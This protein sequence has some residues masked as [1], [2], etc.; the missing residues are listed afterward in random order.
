MFQISIIRTEGVSEK[1]EFNFFL[2]GKILKSSSTNSE[3]IYCVPKKANVRI[4]LK[5]KI[6]KIPILSSSFRTDILPIEEFQWLPLS[7]SP[8]DLFT[9]LPD[10]VNVPRVLIHVSNGFLSPVGEI[11]EADSEEN[12]GIINHNANNC[13]ESTQN[14]QE[15]KKKIAQIS[16]ENEK[17]KKSAQKFEALYNECKKELN[18]FKVKYE[19]EYKLNS[20]LHEKVK[21]LY[22]MQEEAKINAK[23]REEFLEGLLNHKTKDFN[24]SINGNI[25][26][27]VINNPIY[28]QRVSSATP[29]HESKK[30]F[31]KSTL[32]LL[33]SNDSEVIEKDQHP[34]RRVL[35]ENNHSHSNNNKIIQSAL[36]DFLQKTKR[37][38]AFIKESG[39]IYRFG[40]KKVSIT[41]KE[42][43]LLCRVGTGFENIERFISKNVNKSLAISPSQKLHRRINTEAHAKIQEDKVLD[44]LKMTE[45]K[46]KVVSKENN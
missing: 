35:S 16:M 9:I 3:P 13:I 28:E 30:F 25:S 36:Q 40:T 4:I 46:E 1:V 21:I 31:T 22:L 11:S 26:S 45:K 6:S 7:N 24:T 42:G 37:V 15:L 33:T 43:K 17:Y 41:L 27:L 10:E 29:S 8:Q 44:L 18:L 12:E 19:Q 38:G 2:E 39:N 32:N 5:S 14:T 23:M 20:E 34:K